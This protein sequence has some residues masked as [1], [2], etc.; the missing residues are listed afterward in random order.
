MAKRFFEKAGPQDW[1]EDRSHES[2]NYVNECCHCGQHFIG[3][4]RRVSCRM[5]DRIAEL[6]ADKADS[7]EVMRAALIPL[8][9]YKL[10]DE[11]KPYIEFS[12]EL[13]AAFYEAHDKVYAA[14]AARK[15]AE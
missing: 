13:R 7:A 12:S 3:H 11:R 2:G 5:C 9:V 8:A 1:E 10:E 14:L 15:G 6:E 4:K